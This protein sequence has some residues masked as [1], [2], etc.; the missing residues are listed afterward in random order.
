MIAAKD[1]DLIQVLDDPAEILAAVVEFYEAGET[2]MAES[3]R[4]AS[5][6]L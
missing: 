5:V 2:V 6:L 4:H 1:M 3:D